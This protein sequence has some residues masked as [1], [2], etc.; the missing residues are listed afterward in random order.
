MQETKRSDTKA[1]KYDQP[2]DLFVANQFIIN[3]N[4]INMKINM[5]NRYVSSIL[6]AVI[7]SLIALSPAVTVAKGNGN[8]EDGKGRSNGSSSKEF[9]LPPGLVGKQTLPQGIA[10][11]VVEHDRDS[12][13]DRAWGDNDNRMQYGTSS[14]YMF[15]WFRGWFNSRYN[16]NT[17]RNPITT[18]TPSTSN[19]PPVINGITAPTLL[20]VGQAGTWTVKA[21]D[22][23]NGPLSYSVNWGD[24]GFFRSLL[25]ASTPVMQTSTFTHVYSTPGTY[26]VVFIV[27]DDHK[28]VATSSVTV[29]VTA[30]PVDTTAPNLS[31]IAS[32]TASTTATITWTTDDI[33]TSKVYF[34]TSNPIDPNASTTQTVENN[35]LVS[36]HSITLGGLATST[37][38]YFVVQSINVVNIS[39]TSGQA[40][41]TTVVQ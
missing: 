31:S 38:Y 2:N 39:A 22:P 6:S 8:G 33:S 18:T 41:F 37:T 28:K 36:N 14:N 25:K 3:N 35:T 13:N 12:D 23:E 7:V 16:P 24:V 40:S 32:S 9:R 34:S 30:A 5:K 26:T 19:R 20:S 10:K 21:S 11:K 4:Q 29:S 15:N 1:M 17:P 27:T